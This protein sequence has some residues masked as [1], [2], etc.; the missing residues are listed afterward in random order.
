MV[1]VVQL[2]RASDCGSECR[3]FESHLPPI[4]A[5]RLPISSIR[6]WLFY[7]HTFPIYLHLSPIGFHPF[8]IYLHLPP[9]GFHPASIVKEKKQTIQDDRRHPI[10]FIYPYIRLLT[11][12]FTGTEDNPQNEACA[13]PGKPCHPP[14]PHPWY[15]RASLHHQP[16]PEYQPDHPTQHSSQP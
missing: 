15:N 16:T 9:I 4:K 11:L 12:P 7:F 6:G 14:E 5:L 13:S 10:W 2:V 8:Q 1:D 3:G